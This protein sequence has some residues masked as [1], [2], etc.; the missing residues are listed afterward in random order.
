M[1]TELDSRQRAQDRFTHIRNNL[2]TSVADYLQA[3]RDEDWRELD[4]AS[5]ETWRVA[6]L[7]GMEFGKEARNAII[8]ALDAEGKTVREIAAAT[9]ASRGTVNNDQQG[10]VSNSGHK[11]PATP[12]QRA[13]RDRE[14]A[15]KNGQGGQVL[16]RTQIRQQQEEGRVL[17]AYKALRPRGGHVP[18]RELWRQLCKQFPDLSL[19]EHDDTAI[20]KGWAQRAWDRLSGRGEM[21]PRETNPRKDPGPKNLDGKS[22]AERRRELKNSPSRGLPELSR[23]SVEINK[24]C[25]ILEDYDLAEFDLAGVSDTAWVD[26]TSI[27]DDLVTLNEWLERALLTTRHWLNGEPMRQKI[28]KLREHGG[29]E[30]EAATANRLA[31]RLERKL[32]ALAPA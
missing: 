19:P 23:L 9:G 6:L 14:A 7:D 8:R 22:N 28:A 26:A 24:M 20:R 21:Q 25:M 2:K 30:E 13:A 31:D 10:L 12:R 15:R 18:G 29:T 3:L 11:P 5:V 17:A 16:T 4:F 27:Y 32:E 1:S